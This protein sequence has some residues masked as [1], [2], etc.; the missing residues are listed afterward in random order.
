MLAVRHGVLD[1]PRR[2]VRLIAGWMIFGAL[3]WAVVAGASSPADDARAR[4]RLA[5]RAWPGAGPGSVAVLYVHR[6]RGAAARLSPGVDGAA[7]GCSARP[8]GWRSPTTWCRRPCSTRSPPATASGSSC[9]PA[10][11][12]GGRAALRHR[13]WV[14]RAWL[15]RYRF[16]P[17]EWVW[18]VVT[19]AR[20]QPL[21][22]A[23][24]PV[25][26]GRSVRLLFSLCSEVSECQIR[27]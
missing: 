26:E 7:G 27:E 24:A 2:H 22:R 3:S 11:C 20:V 4:R 13:G 14:S 23:V 5:A 1:Q 8:G 9:V 18:R 25:A 15:A 10:L 19:Y 16:G 21:R 6:G 17:L 12:S